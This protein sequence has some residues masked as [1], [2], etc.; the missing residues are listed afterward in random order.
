MTAVRAEELA[1]V[2]GCIDR[3]AYLQ[4][5]VVMLSLLDQQPRDEVA[6]LLGV[7]DGL[8]SWPSPSPNTRKT[9]MPL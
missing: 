7:S 2:K 5:Q 4:R 8:S 1:R 9:T 6:K 3:M